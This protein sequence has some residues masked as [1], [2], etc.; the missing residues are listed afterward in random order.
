MSSGGGQ[1]HPCPACCVLRHLHE[2]QTAVPNSPH[3]T[4]HLS[5]KKPISM[6]TYLLGHVGFHLRSAREIPL[7][8]VKVSQPPSMC[9]RKT[10]WHSV[11][12]SLTA[13]CRRGCTADKHHVIPENIQCMPISEETAML[14][15]SLFSQS[16]GRQ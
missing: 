5:V 2:L 6:L 16:S 4:L 1:S 14:T 8:S 15:H 10:S 9:P 13:Q 11:T 3:L 7:K 12:C